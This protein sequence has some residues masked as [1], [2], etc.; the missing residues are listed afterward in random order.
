M[1]CIPYSQRITQLTSGTSIETT[2]V[3]HWEYPHARRLRY[4][5]Y[6]LDYQGCGIQPVLK[7]SLSLAT[8]LCSNPETQISTCGHQRHP[9]PISKVTHLSSSERIG[10][11]HNPFRLSHVLPAE[12]RFATLTIYSMGIKAAVDSSPTMQHGTSTSKASLYK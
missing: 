3:V 12:A 7:M 9:G 8:M 4:G 11:T 2:P 5:F 10:F 1:V 6:S